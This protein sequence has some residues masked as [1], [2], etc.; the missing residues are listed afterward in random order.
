MALFL[1]LV[2]SSGCPFTGSLVGSPDI[3]ICSKSLVFTGFLLV[4]LVVHVLV[5]FLVRHVFIPSIFTL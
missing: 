1:C 3:L 4:R 2:G 5:H